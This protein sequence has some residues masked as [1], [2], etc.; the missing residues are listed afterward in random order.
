MTVLQT[1]AFLLGYSV[2]VGSLGLEPRRFLG[3]WFTASLFRHSHNYPT[4]LGVTRTHI[5]RVR[6]SAPILW[7]TRAYMELTGIAPVPF[8][9]KGNVLLLSLKPHGGR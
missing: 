3:N 8:P 6:S 4:T 7:T 5:D 9:C 1:V 2:M